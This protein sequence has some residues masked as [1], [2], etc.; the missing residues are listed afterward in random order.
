[1]KWMKLVSYAS[2]QHDF[3]FSAVYLPGVQNA[4][5][6]ALS[7]LFVSPKFSEIVFSYSS[8]HNSASITEKAHE[9]YPVVPSF[10]V[11]LE[12]AMQK[13]GFPS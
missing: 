6:D 2:V 5:A 13:K 10:L 4:V 7:R 3:R 9:F 12:A 11:L 1:M 8:L